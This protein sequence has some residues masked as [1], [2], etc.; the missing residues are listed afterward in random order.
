MTDVTGWWTNVLALVGAAAWLPKV[1]ALFRRPRV[2]LIPAG[3][4]EL[5]Y[6][7][8]GPTLNPSLAF[9][10]ERTDA[11]VT[12]IWFEVVHED[13]TRARFDGYQLHETPLFYYSSSG[14]Q[15]VH[16]RAQ[17]V[18]A[19]VLTPWQI[20]ERRVFSQEKK[21]RERYPAL[22]DDYQRTIRRLQ[23][24]SR[25]VSVWQDAV[26]QSTE[27]H[28]LR[29]FLLDEFF[30][31]V[32]TYTVHVLASVASLSTPATVSFKFSFTDEHRE[33]LSANRQGVEWELR[34]IMS[35]AAGQPVE[36]P[37]FA[38]KFAYPLV[39]PAVSAP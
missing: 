8:F 2:T 24:S 16:S 15:T 31:K 33:L 13:G 3:T 18:V 14:E 36:P 38:Y 29:E 22:M 17:A 28:T 21:H 19:I 1:V 30:W 37:A 10:T 9:R 26:F 5:G 6:S 4:V 35:Q 32:G 39:R 20:V 12:D 25:D 27:Y 11:L 7:G 23:S 34:R